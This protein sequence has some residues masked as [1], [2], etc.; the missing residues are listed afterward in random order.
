MLMGLIYRRLAMLCG[1]GI[2]FPYFESQ[3]NY[4]HEQTHRIE[5]RSTIW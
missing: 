2:A 3:G 4:T 1:V 5:W